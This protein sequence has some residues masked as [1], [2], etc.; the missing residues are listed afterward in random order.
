MRDSRILFK[1]LAALFTALLFSGCSNQPKE[2]EFKLNGAK[3]P[4]TFILGTHLCRVPAPDVKE[5]LADMDNL[6][7]HGFNMI[8][9]QTHWAIDEPL[10]GKYEF[11]RYDT[12]IQH[13]K[14]LGM[15]V[16]MGFTIEQ[17]P[18]W[19]Y[20]KYPDCRMVG[21][22]G[23]PVKYETQYTVPADGKP[24]PCFDHPVAMMKMKDY[25]HAYVKHFSV[26]DN[27]LVWNTWQEIGYWAEGFM[28][29]N[30][31]YCENSQKHFRKWLNEK[32]GSLENLNKSWGANFGDWDQV[33]PHR[34][35]PIGLPADKDFRYFMDNDYVA[36]TLQARYQAIK[37][38]DPMKR[39]VFAHKGGAI[40]GSGQDWTYARCEDFMGSSNYPAWSSFREWDDHHQSREYPPKK[41][42][43]LYSEMWSTLALN[44]DYIRSANPDNNPVWAAEF[45]GG[46]VGSDFQK[47]R[48]PAATDIRRWMLTAMSCG[49]STISFW[50]TRAEI[51]AQENNGFSLLDSK[52]NTTERYEEASRIGKLLRENSD[53]FAQ[54]TRQ[55]SKVGIIINED[56]YQF[57]RSFYGTDRHLY[58][59]VRGWY[60][61]LWRSGYPVDFVNITDV[62]AKTAGQYKALI[63]PFPLELSDKLA[64]QLKDYTSAGGNL[65]CEGAAGRIN[66]NSLAVRGEMSPVIAEMAGV[67]QKSFIEVREP[68][69]EQRWTPRE[70]TWGEFGPVTY[71]EGTGEFKGL[72]TLANFYLQT[73]ECNGGTPIFK[74][75]DD[76]AACEN[77]VGKGRIW[78]LGTFIGHNGTA[79]FTPSV[80]ELCDKFM[81][82]SGV[83]PQKIGNLLVQK[84]ISG[85]KEAWIITNP[86]NADISEKLDV[87]GMKN[88]EVLIG[89]KWEIKNNLAKIKV[90]SLDIIVVIF[91]NS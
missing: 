62:D 42:E 15:Y 47:G 82:L 2:T 63:L 67:R 53:L 11:A 3:L 69:N 7:E 72:K 59:S 18:A 83:P 14:E 38:A 71:L 12:L 64:L 45:Q 89:D 65:I 8:K 5:M 84:R 29:S 34:G 68:N 61:I 20:S 6:K 48:V 55:K 19:L 23:L 35:S 91:K 87:S 39:V 75:G 41:Y 80:L 10:E 56:N 43:S 17:A 24:G 66:E 85:N 73:F 76:V 77:R 30:V 49:V 22:N 44:F 1:I 78:L 28:G 58:N 51:I 60:H 50:V 16:Y 40:V 26:Y 9:I 79:Y 25:I 70:R 4:D 81:Q 36:Q 90:N 52:G 21:R 37:E 27:I 13:A 54:P 57:C 88:P 74:A 33:G 86:T 31:C 46:P 32:Y